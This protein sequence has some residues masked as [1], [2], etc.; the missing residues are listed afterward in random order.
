[1][2]AASFEPKIGE[3]CS[4]RAGTRQ[5]ALDPRKV[6]SRLLEKNAGISSIDLDSSGAGVVFPD[7]ARALID[8]ASFCATGR[9][10]KDAQA[11]LGL[12]FIELKNFV[13]RNA[14]GPRAP[15]YIDTTPLSSNTG[16]LRLFLL[17][18]GSRQI[19]CVPA[20]VPSPPAVAT[21]AIQGPVIAGVEWK[22]IPHYFALRQNIEDLAIPQDDE[23]FRGLKRASISWMQDR[24]AD[25]SSLPSI[26]L[27]D[28][29]SAGFHL[30]RKVAGSVK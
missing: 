21:P 24:V 7:T 11:S 22:D 27:P 1:M 6:V 3:V 14:S 8:P 9:C 12:A 30:M 26:S 2:E 29:L 16:E 15:P 18:R 13:D 5:S 19:A 20:P 28:T 10:S 17:G 4:A 23:R 25:R